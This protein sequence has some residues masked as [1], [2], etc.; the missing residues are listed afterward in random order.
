MM[1]SAPSYR[2]LRTLLVVIL[3]AYAVWTVWT[4]VRA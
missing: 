1:P 4:I 3:G 2:W